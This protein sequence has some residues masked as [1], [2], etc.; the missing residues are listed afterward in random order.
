LT[1]IQQNLLQKKTTGTT[2]DRPAILTNDIQ[3]AFNCVNHSSLLQIMTQQKFPQY[4]TK[5]C[6]E[7][8]TNRTLQFFF[9]HQLEPPQPYNSGLPQG[10]PLSPVLYMIY[11]GVILNPSTSPKEINTTY[12]DDDALVQISKS[13]AFISKRLNE[14]M[15]ERISKANPLNVKYEPQKSDLVFFRPTTSSLRQ[16]NNTVTIGD[17]IIQPKD[18]LKYVGVWLDS[19]LSFRP[20]IESVL[21]NGLRSLHRIRI[22]AQLPGAKVKTIHQLITQAF[23]PALLWGSEAWWT[24]ADHIVRTLSP[25]YNEAA[26]IIIGL[27]RWRKLE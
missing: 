5:W 20:H 22:L 10:S 17:T 13:P 14:R 16:P 1:P 23:L 6:K 27:P 3:G 11:A 25:L 2:P 4:L 18:R 26:R 21:S 19:T 15:L 7:F 8:N 9:N 24:G 12:I